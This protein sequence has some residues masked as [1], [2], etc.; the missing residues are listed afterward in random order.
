MTN[1]Q[2][3]LRV[4]AGIDPAE[5]MLALY[6][7]NTGLIKK[8]AKKCGGLADQEDLMQEGY[9]GLCNAV[10][11]YDPDKGAFTTYAGQHIRAAMFRYIENSG[12]IRIPVHM[13]QLIR[14]YYRACD[15]LYQESGRK[16]SDDE[17]RQFMGLTV[18]EYGTLKTGLHMRSLD[19][20]DRPLKS[21][22]DEEMT[23]YDTIK[24]GQDPEEDVT[25]QILQEDLK[26]ALWTMVDQLPEDKGQLIRERYQENKLLKDIADQKGLPIWKVN[27]QIRKGLRDLRKPNFVKKLRPFLPDRFQGAAYHGSLRRFNETWTSSTEAIAIKMTER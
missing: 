6:Q 17:I 2:L 3:A 14:E 8:F 10:N 22:E 19:S 9:I 21:D 15:A 26:E 23:I 4:K 24:G 5:N 20:L 16:P 12:I 25:D 7:K 13:C 18:K 11:G 27:D 1:E